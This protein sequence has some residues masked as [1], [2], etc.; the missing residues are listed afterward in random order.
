M[1]QKWVEVLW[2]LA[3]YF[4]PASAHALLSVHKY[5]LDIVATV[6]LLATPQ[7]EDCR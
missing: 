1:Y 3:V 4:C 7:G 2:F 6:A 5:S